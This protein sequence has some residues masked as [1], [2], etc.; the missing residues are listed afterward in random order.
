M[1]PAQDSPSTRK[2]STWF[3]DVIP[4]IVLSVALSYIVKSKVAAA[5]GQWPGLTLLGLGAV[6]FASFAVDAIERR[7]TSTAPAVMTEPFGR[8]AVR[9]VSAQMID[10]HGEVTAPRKP[11]VVARPVAPWSHKAVLGIRT[12]PMTTTV[13]KLGNPDDENE[14]AFAFDVQHGRIVVSDGASSSFASRDWS[15]ALCDEF[16]NDPRALDTPESFGAAVTRAVQRWTTSVA[17]TGQVA[18]YAQ[19]GLDRGAFATLLVVEIAM[20][21]KRERWRAAAVGDSCLIQLRRAAGGWNIVT[22]FPMAVGEKFTSYPNLLQ[23]NSPDVVTGLAWAEGELKSGDILI[24]ATDAVSEWMLGPHSSAATGLVSNVW[25]DQLIA[26]FKR[27]RESSEMVND[28]CT[29]VRVATG[30]QALR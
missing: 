14:D 18:W 9:P 11:P 20:V 7:T 27:L 24:A 26:E 25:P 1:I 16:V 2:A 5:H 30:K 28:D 15:R 22:S 8:A 17:P 10:D 13:P 19:Q 12:A 23:T 29:I 3:R 21:D 4:A 6:A